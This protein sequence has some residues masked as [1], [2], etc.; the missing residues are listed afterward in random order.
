[1][2]APAS[3]ADAN[4]GAAPVAVLGECVADAFVRPPATEAGT[5]A[6]GLDVLPGGGPANTAVALARLGTPTR[7]LGRLSSDVFGRLFRSH[8]S[9]SGVDLS[10]AVAADEPSTLAVADLDPD[11]RADYSFHAENTADWQWTGQE[12]ASAAEGPVACLHTGSLA[13]VR[14]PGGGA[15]EELLADVRERATV[16]IDPNVRPLLV[17]PAVYRSAL[18]RWC[19]AADILRLSDDDLAHLVPEG[20][21]PEKAADTFH[22]DGARLVVVTLGADGVFASLDG[23]RLRAAAPPVTVVDSVGAGD[24]FMAGFLH[25][26][27]G[28]GTLGGRL[29]SLR[30]EQVADALDFGARV[31]AAVCAVRGANPPWAS[32]L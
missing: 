3:P 30:R 7:F 32:E 31:A 1:M 19:A 21:S 28:A 20:T 9:D 4:A 23:E 5:P 18:P 25:S 16:S 17:D 6:I 13:L 12:L 15:V 14:Q 11:G 27:Y 26:L 2:S 8:L 22:A 10:R 29:D 24:S